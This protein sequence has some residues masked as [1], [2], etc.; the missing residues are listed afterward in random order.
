[1]HFVEGMV[2]QW[3]MDKLGRAIDGFGKWVMAGSGGSEMVNGWN[4]GKLGKSTGRSGTTI[5]D[6]FLNHVDF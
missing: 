5:W 1:M 3:E 2:G 4:S 6:P